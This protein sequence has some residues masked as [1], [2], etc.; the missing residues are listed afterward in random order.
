MWLDTSGGGGGGASA[1]VAGVAFSRAATSWFGRIFRLTTK[2]YVPRT[3]VGKDAAAASR[4][5]AAAAQ[6]QAAAQAAARAKAAEAARINAAREAAAISRANARYAKQ[7]RDRDDDDD[8]IYRGVP[9]DHHV[10]DEAKKGQ[11]WPG[12]ILGHQDAVLHTAGWTENSMLTSW[13]TDPDVAS[14]FATKEGTMPGV[15]LRVHLSDHAQKVVA[16]EIRVGDESEVLIRGI[17]RD[18]DVFPVTP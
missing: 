18:A 10:Y 17:V 15:I 5:Q 8:W 4:A 14:R 13:T 11:A 3:M 1:A 7:K 9:E 12:D 6:A 16:N 2:A